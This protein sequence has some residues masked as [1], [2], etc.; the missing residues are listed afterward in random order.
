MGAN[1]DPLLADFLPFSNETDFIHGLLT[2]IEKN[3][4]RSF[5]IT[6]CY[7]HVDDVLS[8]TTIPNVV[9]MLSASIPLHLI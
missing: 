9:I 4:V 6:F 5:N 1:Y 7:R 3:L 8:Q 2:K